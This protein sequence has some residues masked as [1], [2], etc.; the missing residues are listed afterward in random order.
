[1]HVASHPW[2]TRDGNDL[3]MEVP[4]TLKEA[5]LGGKANVPT[6]TGPV[7]LTIPAGS[8][9]GRSLR[10]K[11][12]GIPAHAG[13]QAGDLYVKLVVALPDKPDQA[14]KDFAASWDTDYRPRAKF[15]SNM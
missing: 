5:V 13:Q 10:L 1:M 3:K 8:N 14:L 6:L 2:L 4:I 15:G 7:T 9:T 12:K 11:G